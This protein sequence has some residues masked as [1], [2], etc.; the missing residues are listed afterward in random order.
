MVLTDD[1]F[2]SIVAAIEGGRRVYANI[3]KFVFYIFAHATPEVVPFLAFALSGGLIPLPLTVIQ[4]LAVDLGTETLPA[5]ALGRE[6]AEAGLM[7]QPPRPRGEG[8]I[9]RQMLI[10]AW[11]FLGGISA[12]LVLGGFFYVLWRAGWSP[13]DATGKGSSLHHAYL[14]ASTMTFLGIVA[15]QVGTALAARTERR[16]LREVGLTTNRLLLS[17]IA[18]E[19]LFAAV[20]VATPVAASLAMA[21]PSWDALLLLIPFPVIVWGADELLRAQR[22]SRQ[23]SSAAPELLLSGGECDRGGSKR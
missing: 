1:N 13:G 3:R 17:G 12:L 15:C 22:R 10:R 19:L 11:L 4:I 18:F 5:L 2:A 20:V 14:E 21:L 8:V 9:R 6:P 16:S 7:D 23:V